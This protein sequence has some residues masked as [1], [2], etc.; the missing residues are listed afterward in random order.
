MALSHEH[1]ESNI[2]EKIE[3]Y[4][5]TKTELLFTLCYETACM[6]DPKAS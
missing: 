5:I 4:I 2:L 3:I 6:L 1:L